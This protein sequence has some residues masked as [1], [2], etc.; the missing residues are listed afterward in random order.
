[1]GFLSKIGK[2]IKSAFKKIGKGIK[3]AFKSVGKFMDKIGIVG[4]IGLSLLLPGIGAALSGM[5]G[6]VVGGLQ[7]YSGVGA[8]IVNGAG[9]FLARATEI[10]S[11]ITKPFTTITEGVK[12]VVGETLKAGAN[13]LGVDTALLKAGETFSSE[14]LTNLGTSISEAN[15]T[16]IGKQI[17]GSGQA[18]LDSFSGSGL[19]PTG[20]FET[21]RQKALMSPEQKEFM[22]EMQN[23]EMTPEI[24][25]Q[26]LK[27]FDEAYGS[28]D[29]GSKL[30]SMQ[31]QF[32]QPDLATPDM[33][34]SITEVKVTGDSLLSPEVDMTPPSVGG[35]QTMGDPSAVVNRKLS[36]Q[37]EASLDSA[38]D[39]E[40]NP[41]FTAAENQA[42]RSGDFSAIKKAADP[43]SFIDK[44]MRLGRQKLSELP[45]RA[46]DK[47]GSTL[48]DIPSQYAKKLVGLSPDPVYNQVSYATVV[49]TIQE[50]PM[51]GSSMGIDPV[52]YVAN[53][54]QSMG[55][56]PFGFNANMYNE[57]TYINTMRKYGLA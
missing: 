50:A 34:A 55:L 54:Q 27:E 24:E 46:M 15:L 43:E 8:S 10:A 21:N 57:A 2:G 49:P 3:S 41:D 44:T 12:N 52:Q 35:P 48:T 17:T 36:V 11:N 19:D 23:F 56:Q 9:N 31:P 37:A 53:N 42:M 5:W 16:S 13:A 32:A 6:S 29:T 28:Y 1:M 51:V 38:F 33:P 25:A 40:F 4:Q 18:F 20:A 30:K 47:L 22:A 45:E 14:Y 39:K 7:A 26:R